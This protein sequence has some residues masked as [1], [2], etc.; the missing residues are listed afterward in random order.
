MDTKKFFIAAIGVFVIRT[1]MNYLVYG[2]L[3][4]STYQEMA[5]QHPGIF[6]EVI[7]AF[8]LADLFF[9]IVFVYLFSRVGTAMGGGIGAGVRLGLIVALVSPILNSIYIY[10]SFTIFDSGLVVI[11]DVYQL[12]AHGIQGAV[13]AALYKTS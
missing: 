8:V 4:S 6:R 7:P 9:A 13:A 10:F 5:N 3:M 12:V 1:V 2:V 11:D